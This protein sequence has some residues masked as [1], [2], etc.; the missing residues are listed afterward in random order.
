[1]KWRISL[2]QDNM[3]KEDIKRLLLLS[4][5]KADEKETEK[6][7][8]DVLS[9]L[10]YVDK[11][12]EVDTSEVDPLFHFPELKNV[13]AEDVPVFVSEDLRKAMISMG[14]EYKGFLKVESI[15]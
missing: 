4:R 6:I 3:K 14:K 8:E 13:A 9:I 15:L 2:L 1:M 11:L 5:L 10:S 7:T 12:K